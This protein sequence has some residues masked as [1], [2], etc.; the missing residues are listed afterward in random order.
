M[1]D[2]ELDRHQ[3]RKQRTRHRLQEAMLALVLEKGVEDI[4]IQE[5][6]DRADLGRGTFYFHFDDK[7]DLLWSIIEDKIRATE[8]QVI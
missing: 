4:T 2:V 8:R 6:T 5:I 7:D 3:R 1:N